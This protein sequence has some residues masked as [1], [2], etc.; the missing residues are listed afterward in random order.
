M[1]NKLV[2]LW[3]SVKV[4]V[5]FLCAWMLHTLGPIDLCMLSTAWLFHVLPNLYSGT[6]V[7]IPTC[8]RLIRVIDKNAKVGEVS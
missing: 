8:A 4:G 1:W 7:C 3:Y 2:T 5:N 6:R